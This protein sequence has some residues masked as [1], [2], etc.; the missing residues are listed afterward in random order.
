[1]APTTN[2]CGQ[3]HF[4]DANIMCVGIESQGNSQAHSTGYALI[5][6]FSQGYFPSPGALGQPKSL[7]AMLPPRTTPLFPPQIL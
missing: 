2:K 3:V 5:S 6:M 4:H 7:D 1:M